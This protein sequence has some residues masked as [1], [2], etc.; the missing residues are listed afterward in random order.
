MKETRATA[1][2]CGNAGSAGKERSKAPNNPPHRSA[3]PD[4]AKR[5]APQDG[6]R[7]LAVPSTDVFL[8]HAADR[9]RT[10]GRRVIADV[11]E[12]GRLLAACKER[13]GHGG[14]LPWLDHEFG[15]TDRTALN[16]MRVYELSL[17]S[18]T[19]SD[20]DL[21]MR[22][23]YALAAPSTPEVAREEVITRAEADERLKHEEVRPII[24][25]H[26]PVAVL[27][28]A[29]ALG[30]ADRIRRSNKTGVAMSPH[31]ERADDFYRTPECAVNALLKVESFNGPIWECACGDGAIVNVLRQAGHKV[32]ATNLI[33]YGC[34]DSTTGVDF[35]MERRAPDGV[36]TILTNPPFM[37]AN[38]FVRHALTLAPRVVMFLRFLFIESQKRCDIIDGCNGCC[39]N[40]S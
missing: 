7:E 20:L 18:E 9:I 31:A 21:P 6:H 34:P 23:L 1:V 35:L 5:P 19:V 22:S 32:I 3:Q 27:A 11:I 39:C 29:T 37:H 4:P 28:A 14:W 36:D 8:A 2:G 13:C 12:I 26:S 30:A 40:W 38:A 16:F 10:L 17:K 33:D 25:A 15:W 24:A